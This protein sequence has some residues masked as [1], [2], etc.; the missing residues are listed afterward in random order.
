VQ[1]NITAANGFAVAAKSKSKAFIVDLSENQG[2]LNE[3]AQKMMGVS[4]LS[5]KIADKQ[6]PK[7]CGQWVHLV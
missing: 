4:V 1:Q 7:P 3:S 2:V 6:L 5:L